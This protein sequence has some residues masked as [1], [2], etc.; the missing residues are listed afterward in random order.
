V[1]DGSLA[2]N[3][4]L[5]IRSVAAQ[6]ASETIGLSEAKAARRLAEFGEDALPDARINALLR[7]LSYFWGPIPWTIEIGALP[8]AAVQHW[9]HFAMIV[10]MLLAP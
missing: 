2:E 7:L 1:P 10:A 4:S 3:A 8:S 6:S 9:A 5:E